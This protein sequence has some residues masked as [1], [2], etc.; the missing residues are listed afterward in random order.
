[1]RFIAAT[2]NKTGNGRAE[3]YLLTE[4]CSGGPLID[5]MQRERLKPDQVLKIF[6]ALCAA[7]HH[8]HDRNPPITHRDLKVG[9]RR[10]A[11]N[12]SVLDRKSPV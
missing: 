5:V 3:F 2:Q 8:M 6:Y 4:L 10:P 7:V 9:S 12:K 11:I 1:M